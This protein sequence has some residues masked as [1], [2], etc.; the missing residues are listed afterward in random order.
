MFEILM[1]LSPPKGVGQPVLGYPNFYTTLEALNAAVI[2][3]LAGQS[4]FP[5]AKVRIQFAPEGERIRKVVRRSNYRATGKFPSVKNGRMMHWESQYELNA[6][7][8]LE[9]SPYVLAYREQPAEIC[10]DGVA[11]K[12]RHYPDILVHLTSGVRTFVEVKP[13]SAVADTDLTQRTQRLATLL[14]PNGYHY[15]MVLAEHL[16]SEAY[17]ENAKQLLMYCKPFMQSAP[18]EKIR[19]HFRHYGPT[20][21]GSLIQTLSH[22]DAKQWIYQ[23]LL[24]SHLRADFSAPLDDDSIVYWAD[25]G[26]SR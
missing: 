19:S 9:L 7:L 2:D 17:L 22:Q 16:E 5:S 23:M 4:A 15:V 18:W 25:A 20:P 14:I 12:Q 21:L 3:S 10:F 1:R 11:G 26:N 24:K 8:I 6:F 13:S